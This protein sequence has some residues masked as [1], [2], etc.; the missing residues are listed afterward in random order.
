VSEAV[1][2]A[3]IAKLEA[4]TRR[5]EDELDE[6]RAHHGLTFEAPVKWGL[7]E[8]ESAVLG[9]IM[10]KEVIGRESILTLLYQD[11]HPDRRPELKII[12]IFVC[13]LRRKVASHGVEIGTLWGRGY[14]LTPESKAIVREA[15]G[16]NTGTT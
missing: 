6:L 14:Y 2:R 16:I 9:I 4:H 13:R 15:L 8:Y 11:R 5:L 10:A 7:T 12:D 1:L 3:R